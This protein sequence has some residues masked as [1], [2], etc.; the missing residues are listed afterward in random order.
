MSFGRSG[1]IVNNL[2]FMSGFEGLGGSINRLFAIYVS[3][4][5]LRGFVFMRFRTCMDALGTV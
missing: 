5:V 3:R 4:C 1:T 2:C